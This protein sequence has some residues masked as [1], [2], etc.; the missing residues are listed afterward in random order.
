MYRASPAIFVARAPILRA[1]TPPARHEPS[2]FRGA[3]C[4]N[5]ARRDT[6]VVV[7][8]RRQRTAD[9][10]NEAEMKY[11]CMSALPHRPPADV[12]PFGA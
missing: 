7:Y 11:E 1:S 4:A 12:L 2:P 9:A 8:V 5:A 3:L 6:M 10:Q